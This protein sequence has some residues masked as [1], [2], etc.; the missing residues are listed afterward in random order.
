MFFLFPSGIE[1]QRPTLQN[2]TENEIDRISS[3][4]LPLEESPELYRKGTTPPDLTPEHSPVP[5]R[6]STSPS[7]SPPKYRKKGTRLVR[8]MNMECDKGQDIQMLLE[9][10][11]SDY[12]RSAKWN[13]KQRSG[14]RRGGS[15]GSSSSNTTSLVEEIRVRGNE[16]KYNHRLTDRKG[17]ESP[18]FSW[19]SYQ[20]HN[21]DSSKQLHEQDEEKLSNYEMEMKPL[22]RMDSYVQD[23]YS[24]QH[25]NKLSSRNM[26]EDYHPDFLSYGVQRLKPT[27]QNKENFILMS[28][29]EPNVQR[30]ENLRMNVK[31]EPRSRHDIST[32]PNSQSV[33]ISQ[34]DEETMVQY[35]SN[36]VSNLPP[37]Q[38]VIEILFFP[39]VDVSWPE[40]KSSSCLFQ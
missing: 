29:S 8:Q 37:Y 13:E 3:E 5:S 32:S 30:L 33:N 20:L 25:Y 6:S 27:M 38:C 34:S 28:P 18:T 1:Y 10:G 16:C 24:E 19:T 26:M 35:K 39:T 2:S 14:T 15:K 36:S 31:L 7:T 17:A 11:R 40:N 4:S 12:P 22:Q 9:G 21:H 23:T